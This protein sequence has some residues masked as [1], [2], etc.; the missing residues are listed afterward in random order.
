MAKIYYDTDI[1][2][3]TLADMTIGVIGYGNQG[4]AHALNMRDS[5]LSVRVGT[6]PGSSARDQA[7]RDGFG[8]EDAESIATNCDVLAIMLPDEAV[9]KVYEESIEPYI[10]S[11]KVFVFAHG[12]CVHHKTLRLP[13]M[14]DILLVAPTGPGRKLRSLYLEGKGL[15]AL[16][17]VEQDDSGLGLQ[18]C[19]AY[20]KAIGCMRAGAIETTFKEETVTD[21]FCEQSVLCGGMPELIKK[22][23]AVAVEAGYQPE[24]AYISCLK[25]VKLIADLLFDIGIDG[26]REAI[27]NTAKFGSA[28]SGPKIVNDDTKAKL[29]EVLHEIESGRFG[30]Q[31]LDDASAGSP[32]IKQFVEE[33]RHS[34]IVQIGK[35]LKDKLDF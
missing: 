31:L 5:G 15:P 7:S 22:S 10:S 4:M 24:L 28:V 3:D 33:E 9:P 16:V 27:S 8:R 26:M 13:E 14:A 29:Q 12:F 2:L 32:T 1:E 20:A 18:R 34:Q 25:E 35:E 30:R 11:N 19:L 6:R 23:F 17:A 21:L